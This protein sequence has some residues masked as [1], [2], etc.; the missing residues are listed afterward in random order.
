MSF[1]GTG[2]A[3]GGIDRLLCAECCGAVP[4]IAEIMCPVCGRYEECPDCKR[5]QEG[6]RIVNRSAVRYDAL[7]KEW[8]ARYKYRGDER[9]EPLFS[10]MIG[11][12]FGLL[13]DELA[14]T[15]TGERPTVVSYVPLSERRLGERGFNQAERMAVRLSREKRL[16]LVS[17]L[18]R[19]RHTEKQSYKSR[20]ER[21]ES[22]DRAFAVHSGGLRRMRDMSAGG[23]VN[24]VIV[25]DV[26]TTGSTLNR[27][28]NEIKSALGGG[29]VVYG[30]TWAR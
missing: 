24:I 20:R 12:A 10:H 30:L 13:A 17:L 19:T 2:A 18:E 4:W 28:A 9:L 27:C 21:L 25:D 8:L 3:F 11:Y 29:V 1:S 5:R 6:E 26:Y 15:G 7:M 14:R 16:P 23:S 22:L